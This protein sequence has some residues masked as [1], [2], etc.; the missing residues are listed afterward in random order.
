MKDKKKLHIATSPLSNKIFCGHLIEKGTVWAANK[1]DVTL[2]A[3]NA[4]L[5]HCI[6][7]EKNGKKVVLSGDGK[8]YTINIVVEEVGCAL[9]P[10]KQEDIIKALQQKISAIYSEAS[11]EHD[12]DLMGDAL[13]NIVSI[14]E[15][16]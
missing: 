13:H 12:E 4:V 3:L 6:K 1:Q 16:K 9:V 8:K 15:G 2:D 5:N 7:L 11:A 14:C 10:V